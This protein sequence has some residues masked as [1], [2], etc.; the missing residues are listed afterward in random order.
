MKKL[1]VT[2]LLLSSFSFFTYGK[3]IEIKDVEYRGPVKVSKPIMIDS[4]NIKKEKWDA[5]SVL[6]KQSDY[7]RLNPT[8]GDTLMIIGGDDIQLHYLSVPFDNERFA[9]LQT[10]LKGTENYEMYLDGKKTGKNI[11]VRPG[12]HTLTYKIL[13]LPEEKDTIVISLNSP[14]SEYITS[15]STGFGRAYTLDDVIY[16]THFNKSEISPSGNLAI[17]GTNTSMPGKGSQRKQKVMDLK[18]GKTLGNISGENNWF[19][20]ADVLWT[21][22]L[23]NDGSRSIIT[24]NPITWEETLFTDNIPEGDF[25]IT[26]D[27]KNLIYFTRDEGPIE[28]AD[29]YQVLN[30]E[31]RQPG[32]RDRYGLSIYSIETGVDQPLTFGS[33]NVSLEDINA[34]S[35]KLLLSTMKN[36]FGKR[37]TTL[38]SLLEYDLNNGKID[39]LVFEDG[40]INRAQYSPDGKSILISGSPEA[41]KGIGKNVP[42]GRI[43]NMTEG[44]LFIMDLTTKNIRPITKFFNPSVGYAEWNKDNMIYLTAEDK[45]RVS[46]FRVN[47]TTEEIVKLNVP[48]DIVLS[49]SFSNNGKT[50]ILVAESVS[51][52]DNLYLIESKKGGYSFNKLESPGEA[53]LEGVKL[54]E[55]KDFDF[56]NSVGDTIN[57]RVYFPPNFDPSKK[58]PMIVNYYGGCSPTSRN[59]AT[60]Y[61]HHLYANQGYIVYVVNPSGATGF[62]Q[63]FASRHVNTAG[64]GV[65]RDI[66]EGTEKLL[67]ESPY[68]DKE[69]IGCIGA[70]YG[71][72]MTQ[73][74]QT[75]TDLFAAAISHAGISD[76]TSYWGNGY[77]GYSYSEVSMADSYPWSDKELFVDQSPLYNADKVNT[78]LLFLHG[79]VDTNVPPMESVQMFTALKLLGKD[80]ALVEVTD[81][82]HHILEPEK[83]QK[84]QDVIFAWF[85]K[86]L[87]DDPN[88]WNE[89][90]PPNAL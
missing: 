57:G 72:F 74:L 67:A 15:G 59:F 48:E 66:I 27:R 81:Q 2:T 18:T 40:F 22:R 38:F 51:N 25:I 61:P 85:S 19:E 20:D 87:Q 8:K 46:L 75:V 76:H 65:A 73:Y 89:L 23:N 70:S 41:L 32:W 49:F 4:V 34:D 55:V 26:P 21:T 50:G 31:D 6:S 9:S 64:E 90:F 45:D 60:R 58:Y 1:I 5:K 35:S 88:W 82:N 37:P 56:V 79:D 83:R 78:P 7:K 36:K 69:K 44:E 71:G 80:T 33:H 16:T 42:E 14:Q 47:P 62:G 86:Y 53:L 43:P 17:I 28:D 10:S 63:E 52:P 24:I 12:S 29:I 54:A 84:W 30:P 77:W 3:K 11:K 39:T 68:I 13:T